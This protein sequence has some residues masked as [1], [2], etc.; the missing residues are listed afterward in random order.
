MV[1]VTILSI[2]VPGPFLSLIKTFSNCHYLD[3]LL[4]LLLHGQTLL[5]CEITRVASVLSSTLGKPTFC[6]SIIL[7]HADC[8]NTEPGEEMSSSETKEQ[9]SLNS[10]LPAEGR[11]EST[12]LIVT[13]LAHRE[14]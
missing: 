9:C 7:S 11:D 14:M 4:V 10:P 6:F 1:V 5:I 2:S 8:S 12:C 13:P 3:I